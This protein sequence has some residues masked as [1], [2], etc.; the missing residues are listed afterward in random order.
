MITI[1]LQIND[2]W[3]E[4]D[5]SRP[6]DLSMLLRS[7][8]ENVNCFWAPE[9]AYEPV[10]MGSFVGST[11]EGGIVNF[12][13]VRFNPHGNGTHTECVGHIA[14]ERYVL[15]ECL[16]H[17]HFS[18]RLVSIYPQ[19]TE[20]GD[21]VVKREQLEELVRPGEVQALV[22]RTLP[23]DGLKQRA[24]YSGAN[25]PYIHHEAMSYLVD[26]GI[27]HFLTDLPSVDREEDGGALLAHHAFWQYPDA[28]RREA[29]ITELMYAPNEVPDGDYLLNLQTAS[30]DLDASPS[31]PVLYP[32]L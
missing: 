1:R 27:L 24:H 19:K 32:L 22:L 26:C 29:T 3:R 2:T 18:A 12:F 21:R 30:F 10:R 31:R 20:E 23:N 8:S 28:V 6:I 25:P 14:R 16:Q 4:A 5:L 13:N 15:R 11:A 17:A 9:V 7:G